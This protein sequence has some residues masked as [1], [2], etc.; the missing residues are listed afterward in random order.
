MRRPYGVYA[1]LNR[2]SMPPL[3]RGPPGN[4]ESRL[5]RPHAQL[6]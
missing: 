2:L 1:V 5:N 3:P 4:L 6:S